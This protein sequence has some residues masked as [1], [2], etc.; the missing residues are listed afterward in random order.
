MM[1][2]TCKYLDI[3][4]EANDKYGGERFFNKHPANRLKVLDQSVMII[5]R[6]SNNRYG[7][8]ESHESVLP[9]YPKPLALIFNNILPFTNVITS[10]L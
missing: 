8:H 4:A 7:S 6:E 10:I 2:R 3:C 5:T 9:P 1:Q